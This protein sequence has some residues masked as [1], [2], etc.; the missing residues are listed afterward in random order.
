MTLSEVQLN[1]FV[2]QR[3]IDRGRA[4]S[5]RGLVVLDSVTDREAHAFCVG[6]QVYSVRLALSRNRLGGT[7]TCPAFGD[8]GPCKHIAAVALAIMEDQRS[9]WPSNA[10]SV[11]IPSSACTSP[12]T[13]QSSEIPALS[14]CLEKLRVFRR[15]LGSGPA[16]LR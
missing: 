15:L 3:Y 1:R 10:S 13:R 7:C 14:R 11:S 4:Y 8:F 12:P 6:G 2:D 5:E 16:I 9:G